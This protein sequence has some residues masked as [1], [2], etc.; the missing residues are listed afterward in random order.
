[1]PIQ[2]AFENVD[3]LA[4]AIEAKISRALQSVDGVRIAIVAGGR[5]GQDRNTTNAQ[6]KPL[7]RRWKRDPFYFNARMRERIRFAARGLTSPDYSTRKRAVDDM[8][9]AMLEGVAENVA[10]QRNADASGFTKLTPNYAAFKRRRFGHVT[11][12]LRASGDLLDGL[13]VRVDKQR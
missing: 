2:V 3:S 4:S 13:K 11:P 8:G 5:R 7:S 6:A 1:M 12:I 9:E 10:G